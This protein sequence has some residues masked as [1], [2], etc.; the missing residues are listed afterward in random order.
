MKA[1]VPPRKC[2]PLAIERPRRTTVS[3]SSGLSVVA[4]VTQ[5]M[6]MDQGSDEGASAAAGG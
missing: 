3:E 6:D 1:G 4:L 2:A 5:V